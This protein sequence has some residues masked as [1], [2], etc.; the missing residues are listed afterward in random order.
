MDPKTALTYE[1]LRYATHMATAHRG[2]ALVTGRRLR[3][4]DPMIR[5]NILRNGLEITQGPVPFHS[6]GM[7]STTSVGI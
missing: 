1:A 2:V 3:G 7:S 4:Q 6:S 5:V